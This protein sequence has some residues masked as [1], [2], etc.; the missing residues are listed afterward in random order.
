MKI[1]K[2]NYSLIIFP[3]ISFIG[4]IWQAQY[5]NDGYHWGFIFANALDLINGKVPFKEFFI[6]YGIFSTAIHALSLIIFNKS[7]I[8]LMIV[9]CL[10]YSIS[11]LLIGLITQKFILSKYISF[12]ATFIIFALYPWPV[13]PWPNFVSFFFIILFCYLY[14]IEDKKFNYLSGFSL[15][16]AYLSYTTV[17]NFIIFPFF[18]ILLI[19]IIIYLKKIDQNFIKKNINCLISFSLTIGIFILYLFYKG[20]IDIWLLYQKIPFIYAGANQMTVF[21]R[22]EDY[23][24]FLLIY[25][26]KNFIYEPQNSIFVF[27]FISN[28]YLILKI[29]IQSKKFTST[30]LNLLT[31]NFLILF[32]NVY[33]QLLDIDKLATSLSLGVITLMILI[34]SIKSNENKFFINFVILFI[35]LYSLF[36]AFGLENTKYGGSRAAYYKNLKNIDLTYND[37]T[38]TYF[39]YQKWD[40]KSWYVLNSFIKLQNQIKK[41]CLLDYGANLTSN[42]F[43][44]ILMDYKKIQV[45]PFF[46]KKHGDAYR[47]IFDKNFLQRLQDKINKNNIII[48]SNENNSKLLDLSTYDVP[49]KISMNVNSTNLMRYIYIYYPKECE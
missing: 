23:S 22:L 14:T 39:A 40:E 42:A 25:S 24:Y 5:T 21:N 31:I 48:V 27:I 30:E 1:S 3:I 7:M 10:L 35:S 28:I 12:F 9:T 29:L 17:Y 2:K 33:A 8:S 6:E 49:K 44:Y 34:N 37:K 15:G 4:G 45:I 46:Y 16:F 32:L 13:S 20:L 41:R 19:F 36:F 47:D 43:Y 26:F 18:V 38:I 11:I